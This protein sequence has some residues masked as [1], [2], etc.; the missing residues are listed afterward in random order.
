MSE[1]DRILDTVMKDKAELIKKEA[2]DEDQ[3]EFI[4]SLREQQKPQPGGFYFS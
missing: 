1:L 3:D 2:P 4:A